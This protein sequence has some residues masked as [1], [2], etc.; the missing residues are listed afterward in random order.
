MSE[1]LVPQHRLYLDESGDHRYENLGDIS[2]RYLTLLGCVFDRGAEYL[3]MSR[4]MEEIKREFWPTADPDKP[5]IFHRAEMVRRYGQFRIFNDPAVRQR[6]DER[7]L[8][9][10]TVPVY[11][12]ICVTIDKQGHKERYVHADHPYH[13]LLRVMLERYAL[14]LQ[15]ISSVG[16]VMAES[17]HTED[18]PLKMVYRHIWMDGTSFRQADLFQKR[19]TSREIK[20]ESKSRNVTGLQLAD[21]LAHP[22]KQ[23]ILS[24][25]RISD[26]FKGR[27]AERVY[28][29]VQGKIRRSP[30][31]GSTTGFG[32]V[33]IP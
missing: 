9:L 5:V 2:Y 32:E 4:L 7:M 19:L 26:N 21:L 28:N 24:E 27:F 8:E 13:Y 6:F 31:T 3:R 1:I 10:L 20:I 15:D 12:I 18:S 23:R 11:T 25:R 17:R 14:F 33:F 30:K 22:L 29:A 16:D